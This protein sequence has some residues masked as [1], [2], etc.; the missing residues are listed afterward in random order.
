MARKGSRRNTGTSAAEAFVDLIAMLPWWIGALIAF[1]SYTVLHRYAYEPGDAGVGALLPGQMGN[2]VA[3]AMWRAFAG[4]GQY[5]LPLFCLVGAAISAFGQTLDVR[6]IPF[7]CQVGS[8]PLL[9]LETT[10]YRSDPN[11]LV[12]SISIELEQS[13]LRSSPQPIKNFSPHHTWKI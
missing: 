6:S 7:I 13:V 3:G 2:F 9:E 11:D 1:G 10:R 12:P 8:D 4:I 5:L